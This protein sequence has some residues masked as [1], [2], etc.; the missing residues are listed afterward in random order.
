MDS[1]AP[2]SSTAGFGPWENAACQDSPSGDYT[3]SLATCARSGKFEQWYLPRRLA[4]CLKQSFNPSH[5]FGLQQNVAADC[6]DF[7]RNVVNHDHLTLVTY[8]VNNRLLFILSWAAFHGTIHRGLLCVALI[9]FGNF[10]S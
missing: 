2:V 9:H 10:G 1:V 7:R 4:H 3:S 6:A 8:R 5:R